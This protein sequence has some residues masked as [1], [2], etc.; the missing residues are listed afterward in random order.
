MPKIRLKYIT[1]FDDGVVIK[2]MGD[3]KD[4]KYAKETAKRHKHKIYELK[5]VEQ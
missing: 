5:E 3:S 2:V 4:L 1:G